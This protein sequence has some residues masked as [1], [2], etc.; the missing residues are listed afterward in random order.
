[1][2]IGFGWRNGRTGA[3]LNGASASR[4]QILFKAGLSGKNRGGNSLRLDF[5]S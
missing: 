3:E 4:Q 1:L 5:K 2:G